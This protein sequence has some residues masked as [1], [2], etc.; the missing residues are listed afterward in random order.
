[1][2][3]GLLML[4][5]LPSCFAFFE[6]GPQFI[7]GV[8]QKHMIEVSADGVIMCTNGINCTNVDIKCKHGKKIVV[9]AKSVYPSEDILKFPNYTL[10]IR[11]VP[12]CLCELVAYKADELWLVTFTLYS[13]SLVIVYFDQKLWDKLLALAEGKYG[14]SKPTV[15]TCL[16]PMS[17]LLKKEMDTFVS[18][19]TKF[20]AEVPSFRGEMVISM[21]ANYISPY[22]SLQK[23]LAV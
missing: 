22:I 18:T 13:V 19:H 12:Q 14:I 23:T 1:M 17:K 9:E 16:H 4:A 20:V 2:L 8:H 7:H 3:V 11:H 21:P 15:P 5:L 6:V 10:P